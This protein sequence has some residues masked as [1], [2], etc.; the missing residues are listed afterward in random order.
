MRYIIG[1]NGPPG[2]GKSWT[3]D[4]LVELDSQLFRKISAMTLA[5]EAYVAVNRITEDYATYKA[6]E[7]DDGVT[8]RLR[9]IEFVE[10]ERREHG[11]GIWFDRMLTALVHTNENNAFLLVE[12][13]GFRE[14]IDFIRTHCFDRIDGYGTVVIAPK[15]YESGDN[16]PGDSRFI[17]TPTVR[18]HRF[19]DSNATFQFMKT[20][21]YD[22]V[23]NAARESRAVTTQ[24]YWKA[25]HMG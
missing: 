9:F 21:Y 11:T 23:S 10:S 20:R 4:R 18:R 3:C 22:A 17:L 6:I 14:E 24:D 8:G 25:I 16:I 15:S 5:W 19:F 1:F 12:S 13:V 2:I 7:F